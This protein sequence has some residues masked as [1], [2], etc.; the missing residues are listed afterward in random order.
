MK[1]SIVTLRK[2][3]RE[4]VEECYSNMDEEVINMEPVHVRG[5][6][7]PA[8]PA[9]TGGATP[10]PQQQVREEVEEQAPAS[11]VPGGSGESGIG[12]NKPVNEAAL[13]KLIRQ[14]IQEV[15]KTA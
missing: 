10:A 4:A 14:T 7:R 13:R 3:I 5:V 1:V 2:M 9:P 11:H 15:L 8:P 6:R 12:G